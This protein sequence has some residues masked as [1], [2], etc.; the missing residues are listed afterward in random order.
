[1]LN[2]LNYFNKLICVF[3]ISI[4]IVLSKNKYIN[5]FLM[6]LPFAYAIFTSNYKVAIVSGI[7]F[8]IYSL[9]SSY[10]I[11]LWIYR[12]WQIFIY[13]LC[14]KY[15]F[16]ERERI[17]FIN[18]IF[19][20]IKSLKNIIYKMFYKSVYKKNKIKCSLKYKNYLIKHNKKKTQEELKNKFVI[21][22]TRYYGISKKRKE[23]GITA[24]NKVD[25]T[26]LCITLFLVIISILY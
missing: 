5:V 23:Y 26:V 7:S 2:K 22:R 15:I 25:S 16:T 20:K 13:A 3:L 24:W 11:F 6:I 12:I 4:C 21:A 10:D 1:M 8:F 19:Y 9:I 17:I 18:R 14:L